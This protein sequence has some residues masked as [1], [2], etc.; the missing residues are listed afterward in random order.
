MGCKSFCQCARPPYQ[1]HDLNQSF[2]VIP[3]RTSYHKLDRAKMAKPSSGWYNDAEYSDLTLKLSDGRKV[4]AHK[5]VICTQ[6][7][8]FRKLCGATSSFKASP[9]VSLLGNNACLLTENRTGGQ[10]EPHHAPRR[11]PRRHRGGPSK[12]QRLHPARRKHKRVALLVHFDR[13]R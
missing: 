7:E 13:H 3:H 4:K 9:R 11:R 1:S 5:L 12:Y 10:A 8:Y 6:N 2:P